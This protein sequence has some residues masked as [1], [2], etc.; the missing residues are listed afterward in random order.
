MA[1]S[2]DDIRAQFSASRK[3][4][5]PLSFEKLAQLKRSRLVSSLSVAD[6]HIDISRQWLDDAALD[7]LLRF[8]EKAGFTTARQ[9]LLAGR[10]VNQSE[11]QPALHMALRATKDYPLFSAHQPEIQEI[12]AQ[13]AAYVERLHRGQQTGA[14]GKSIRHLVHVGIGGSHLGPEMVCRAL[15]PYAAGRIQVHY[16]ANIDA[17]ALNS[18]LAG[19]PPEQALF[20]IV[21]KS[22]RTREVLVN[23]HSIRSWL[24]ERGIPADTVHRHFIAVTAHSD[25]AAAV[26]IARGHCL[27]MPP[28]LGGRYSLWSAAGLSIATYLGMAHFKALLAGAHQVDR[29]FIEAPPSRN[30]PLLLALIDLWNGNVL[31]ASSQVVLPYCHALELLVPYLQQLQMESNGKSTAPSGERLQH[32]TSCVLWGGVGSNSQHAYHQ[33]LHQGTERVAVDFLL[34]CRSYVAGFNHQKWLANA[35]LGQ[36]QALACG[37]HP[38]DNPYSRLSGGRP[39]SFFVLPELTATVL[40][41]LLALFE[42]RVFCQAVLWQTNPFDQFGVEYG[43]HLTDALYET[44]DEHLTD[45]TTQRLR[46]LIAIIGYGNNQA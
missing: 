27:I 38:A 32:R 21:S 16:V 19:L 14:T 9:A 2:I 36:A 25:R 43:K 45:A 10:I 7:E 5:R 28:W 26:G 15:S 41:A 34:V 6:I 22:F 1:T 12:L 42:H 35:C 33:L 29:H 40:G 44:D 4:L 24:L 18:V 8:A 17:R 46:R 3:R 23:L 11:R 31:G 13:I 39:S 20:V 37:N 30:L